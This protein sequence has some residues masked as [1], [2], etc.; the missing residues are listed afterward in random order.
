MKV[1][2]ESVGVMGPGMLGW[3]NTRPIFR[4]EA[5][6]LI[7]PLPA[8]KPTALSAAMLRRTTKHIRIAIEVASQ[9]LSN[10]GTDGL[11]FASVFTASENDA[12]ITDEICR[13]VVSDEPFIAAS[14][15]NNSV[16]N[17]AVGIWSIALK[18]QQPTTCVTGY[19]A[20]FSVGLL[21]A[22]SQL[23][24]E[25]RNM[26]L[27]S[28]DVIS[29]E[30]LWSLHPMLHDFG[31]GLLLTCESTPHSLARLNISLQYDEVTETIMQDDTLEAIRCDNPAARSLPL[32]QMLANKQDGHVILPYHDQSFVQVD[33][34]ND[35][36]VA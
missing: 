35:C 27:V 2:V 32:L 24:T 19:D 11:E 21:E 36:Y 6:L 4:G 12:E 14:S 23:V 3:D 33:I 28:H 13:A 17:A 30:P 34:I 29:G 15:F 5:E 31:V 20:S 1:F 18:S 9:T 26:L 22:A 16:S 8:L 10:A 25:N 7:E